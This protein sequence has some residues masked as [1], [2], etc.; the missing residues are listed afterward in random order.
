MFNFCEKIAFLA[1]FPPET[2][3]KSY[4]RN[5]PYALLIDMHFSRDFV[6]FVVEV[7]GSVGIKRGKLKHHPRLLFHERWQ[8]GSQALGTHDLT[9]GP[10][11][12]LHDARVTG[13]DGL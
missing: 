3:R 5:R 9:Q 2:Y 12:H 4:L 1:A 13:K 6:P 7:G 8:F 10:L 11:L